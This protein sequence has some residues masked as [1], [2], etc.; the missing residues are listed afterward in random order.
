MEEETPEIRSRTVPPVNPLEQLHEL[1]KE[2]DA[3]VDFPLPDRSVE[4]RD[5]NL[6]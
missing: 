3:W 4:N 5:V 1:V 6:P 2:A